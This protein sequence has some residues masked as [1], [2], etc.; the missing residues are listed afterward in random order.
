MRG[1]LSAQAAF[2]QHWKESVNAGVPGNP[3]Y[4]G[5]WCL[6]AGPLGREVGSIDLYR[7]NFI[8]F[9]GA[10]YCFTEPE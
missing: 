8:L 3:C 10:G 6:Q 2:Y 7:Y 9:Y 5:A 1:I 4:E